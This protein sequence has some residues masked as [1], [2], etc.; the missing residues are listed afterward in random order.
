MEIFPFPAVQTIAFSILA[1]S[2]IKIILFQLRAI[3]QHLTLYILKKVEREW[4][5][6]KQFTPS[7]NKKKYMQTWFCSLEQT[8]SYQPTHGWQDRIIFFPKGWT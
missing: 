8:Q 2:L 7:L 6:N 5:L 4:D 3:F 1:F